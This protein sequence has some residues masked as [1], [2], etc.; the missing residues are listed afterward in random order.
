MTKA[1]S[2]DGW[3]VVRDAMIAHSKKITMTRQFATLTEQ[4]IDKSFAH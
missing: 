1:I 2:S 3:W 4:E